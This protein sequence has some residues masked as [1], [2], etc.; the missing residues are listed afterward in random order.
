MLHQA[1][2]MYV[3]DVAQRSVVLEDMGHQALGNKMVPL[4]VLDG[5]STSAMILFV[6]GTAWLKDIRLWVKVFSCCTF[7]FFWKGLLDM[8]TELPDSSGWAVCQ[9]RLGPQAVE[10]ML[11]FNGTS[12]TEYWGR[13]MSMEING[14]QGHWPIRYCSD[15]ILSGHTFVMFLFLLGCIDLYR[16]IS[17]AYATRNRCIIIGEL[18]LNIVVI[19]C[20]VSDLTLIILNHFHYTVDVLLSLFVTLLLYTNAGIAVLTDWWVELGEERSVEENADYRVDDGSIWLPVLLLPCCC[21]QG[22][23]SVKKEKEPSQVLEGSR[24]YVADKFM[25]GESS[26]E[27]EEDDDDDDDGDDGEGDE[28]EARSEGSR[29]SRTNQSLHA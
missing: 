29:R 7:L 10:Y 2:I 17:V 23:Y 12:S 11:G 5:I 25:C 18:V 3:L 6:C 27:D 14:V 21:F 4:K 20:M 28:E 24:W 13:L 15:M 16:K 1:T 9:H 19:G 22:F 8:V 26:E